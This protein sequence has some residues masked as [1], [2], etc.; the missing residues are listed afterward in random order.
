MPYR[1][2]EEYCGRWWH[3]WWAGPATYI[4]LVDLEG[5]P[6]DYCERLLLPA[7][8]LY[9]NKHSMP[10]ACL[11][12]VY[13]EG[14]TAW[15]FQGKAYTRL[16][17]LA[18][19]LEKAIQ[20]WPYWCWWAP[21][22]PLPPGVL[23]TD[24]LAEALLKMPVFKPAPEELAADYVVWTYGHPADFL[25]SPFIHHTRSS[26]AGER[27][28]EICEHDDPR[29]CYPGAVGEILASLKERGLVPAVDSVLF[30]KRFARPWGAAPVAY[31]VGGGWTRI[32]YV[33]G[34]LLREILPR[35]KEREEAGV[36][37]PRLAFDNMP[38]IQGSLL[39]RARKR[40]PEPLAPIEPVAG[41]LST[42]QAEGG[43]PFA[44]FDLL[45]F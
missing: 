10:A 23:D 25:H 8:L 19:V 12:L 39:R 9:M 2:V 1:L 24:L 42:P 17:R 35:M 22:G 32:Y 37:I 28:K 27:W 26:R 6:P 44:A 7:N 18:A 14:E 45:D 13:R 30:G 15:V 33:L 34:H 43:G 40:R 31:K 5:L 4:H 11:P 20:S 29:L 36:G 3:Y 16:D 21:H 41:S 38:D